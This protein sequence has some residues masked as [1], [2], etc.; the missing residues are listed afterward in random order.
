MVGVCRGGGGFV[1]VS[2]L[3]RS[4]TGR[5]LAS[6]EFGLDLQGGED[7]WREQ[8]CGLTIAWKDHGREQV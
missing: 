1:S 6:G 2:R 4:R 5:T 8:G 3:F 7:W